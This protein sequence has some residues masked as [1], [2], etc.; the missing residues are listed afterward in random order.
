MPKVFGLHEVVLPTGVTPEEYGLGRRSPDRAAD[1][2]GSS[3][4]CSTALGAGS[5]DRAPCFVDL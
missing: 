1:C 4:C 5:V 3:L 2:R